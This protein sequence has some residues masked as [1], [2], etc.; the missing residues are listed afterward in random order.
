MQKTKM[1]KNIFISIL[2]IFLIDYFL[3]L[4]FK[5][6]Y[7]DILSIKEYFNPF[8]IYHQNMLFLLIASISFS[9]ILS[10]SKRLF[11]ILTIL[12]SFIVVIEPIS[13]HLAKLVFEKEITAIIKDKEYQYKITYENKHYIFTNENKKLEKQIMRIVY[14]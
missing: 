3:F 13:Y 1:I 11:L 2:A 4:G 14:D 9:I 12:F 8:F 7:I 5:I 6:H 10:I